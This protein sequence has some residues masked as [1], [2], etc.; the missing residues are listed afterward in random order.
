MSVIP[1]VGWSFYPSVLIG[2]AVWTAG[3]VLVIRIGRRSG[4]PAVG[5]WRQAAFHLGTLAALLALISPLDELGDE[6]LFSAHMTQHL[7]LM[8]VT[9]SC[10]VLG[11]PGWLVDASGGTVLRQG[12][13]TLLSPAVALIIFSGV[14]LVWHVPALYDVA[15]DHEWVH[16]TEHLTYIGAAMI[17]WWTILGPGTRLLPVRSAP[18]RILYGFLIA[19]PGTL[20]GAALTFAGTPLYQYYRT[21][22]H[23]FG[24]TA[25]ADQQLAG[26]IMWIPTHMILLL[27]LVIIGARWLNHER[28]G[29]SGALE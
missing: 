22:P 11:F 15:E 24:L 7:L 4:K 3:Y 5:P 26:L 14:M 19:M 25:L 8:Y 12:L 27:C 23:P 6:Y 20:L 1:E 13:R 16:I 28:A 9:A 2:M 21:V 29:H 17:G 18:L 10:W